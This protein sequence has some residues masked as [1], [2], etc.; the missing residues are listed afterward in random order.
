MYTSTIQVE[1]Q[2]GK[3]FKIIYI[4]HLLSIFVSLF[5]FLKIYSYVM[6][7]LILFLDM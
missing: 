2:L 6:F 4:V 1:K 7:K 3:K 5:I